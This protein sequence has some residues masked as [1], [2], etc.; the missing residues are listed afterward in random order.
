MNATKALIDSIP[1]TA[2]VGYR[3]SPEETMTDTTWAECITDELFAEQFI[4]AEHKTMVDNGLYD[5][6]D[7]EPSM[8]TIH[9]ITL[10]EG[11][12]TLEVT[13]TE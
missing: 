9:I 6:V 13:W 12:E 5:S 3:P 4:G 10:R 1:A 11:G 7:L 8:K 2:T